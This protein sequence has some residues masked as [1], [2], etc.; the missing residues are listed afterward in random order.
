MPDVAAGWEERCCDGAAARGAPGSL[1]CSGA[2]QMWRS[3]PLSPVRAGDGLTDVVILQGFSD[4]VIVNLPS[5]S[6]EPFVESYNGL[7]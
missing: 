1:R 4:L 6:C 5:S 3:V 2:V 7:G